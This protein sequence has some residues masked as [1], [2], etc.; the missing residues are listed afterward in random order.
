MVNIKKSLWHEGNG[1]YG[2]RGAKFASWRN[3]TRGVWATRLERNELQ[4]DIRGEDKAD[5]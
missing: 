3:V 2:N 1:R 5:R 4:I